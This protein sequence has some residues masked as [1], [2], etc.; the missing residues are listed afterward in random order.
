MQK[1]EIKRLQDIIEG[2]NPYEGVLESLKAP[3]EQKAKGYG[4]LS[5]LGYEYFY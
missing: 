4:L 1:L 5:G 3:G 2:R